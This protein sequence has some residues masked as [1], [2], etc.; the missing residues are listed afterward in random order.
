LAA[1]LA[2]GGKLF[3]AFAASA[4]LAWQ[5]FPA[6]AQSFAP[7]A[8]GLDAMPEDPAGGR[9]LLEAD[10]LI[11]DFDREI[12]TALG[13]VR[14]YYKGYTLDA[15][16]VTYDQKSGRLIASGGI[17]MLEPSG[18]IVTAEQ[19]D[20][21][22]DFRDGFV[23]SLNLIT[24]ERT[25]FTAQTAERRDGTLTIFRRG[26]YTACEPCLEHPERP[27]L[28]QI[29]AAR[30]IHNESDHRIYYENARLEFF[31][32]PVAYMPI[33]FHP[34]P[35]VKRKTGLL[36]PSVLQSEALGVGVTTPF[37]W[38]LAP[39]YD[40]TF[41]PTFLTRQGLLMQTEW[42]HRLMNGGYTIRLAGIFQNDPGA[43]TESGEPLSGDRDLRGGAHTEGAF[44]LSQNWSF[45]WDVDLTTDRTFN[46][47]YRIPGVQ[48]QD[49]PSTA[50]LTGMSDRNYFSTSGYYI[51]VQR[52]DTEEDLPDDGDPT[53]NDVYVH[54]DQAEQ[55]FVH[56]V[57]DHNYIVDWPVFGG[58]L[59]FDSNLASLTRGASDLRHPPLPFG[60]YYAGVAGS[61][62]RATSR[63]SWKRRMVL[64]GGHLVTPFTYLQADGNW[65]DSDDAA[66]GLAE[67]SATGRAMPAAG[68]EYEW[69]FLAVLGSTTH[70]FGPKVQL[71]ARP[72][73]ARAGSLPN[74]DAQSLE[75]DDTTLFKWDKFAGYDRQEGGTR[76][77]LGLLY[78]GLF[79][80]GASVD[81]IVGRSYQISGENS[82]ALQDHALTG[83]G[84]GLET[85]ESDYL[86]RVTVNTGL[87]LAF[88]ARGRFDDADLTLNRAEL[89]A[90]GGY[91]NSS[92]AIDYTY[93][94]ESPASGIFTRREELATSAAIE[95]VDNWSVLG[96]IV[97]DLRNESRVSNTL[98]LAYAD[99]CFAIS[100]TYSETTDPYT[101]LVSEREIFFRLSLRTV[102]DG[103]FGR[104][105]PVTTD[106]E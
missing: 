97:F 94:R 29:K 40:V 28:W 68:I 89:A 2:K 85:D 50:Y 21:T 31:G 93:L 100:A 22:D 51:R 62:T 15:E 1:S 95:V 27:P 11:Y 64:P 91:G 75:F 73:E 4:A 90:V 48:Q 25:R 34:D 17:R 26:V 24:T 36:V 101:D 56:P 105:L 59:R 43:F 96:S 7:I 71:I 6:L 42:R 70:T 19:L 104:E 79:P 46:R 3:V 66:A 74:E 82:F 67:A 20:I 57:I 12:V 58:E 60:P 72:D 45:G 87:G 8:S 92:G 13:N 77:N 55:A 30:I 49:L 9:M 86:A 10:Q 53:T 39:N 106:E 98:G 103:E 78:Q 14:I 35:T 81:A 33:F 52:E 18:N 63:A 99:E 38:N 84:S 88:T 32:I 80:N 23:G 16:R 102:A 41:A 44:R 69:P 61:F 47:D 37:F 83:V 76:A 65:I 54:D 5:G